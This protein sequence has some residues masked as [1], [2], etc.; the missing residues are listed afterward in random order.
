MG[1][2]A[3]SSD[4]I[5]TGE[6]DLAPIVLSDGNDL[7]VDL[8]LAATFGTGQLATAKGDRLILL[9]KADFDF[10]EGEHAVTSN[11]VVREANAWHAIP[12]KSRATWHFG[13]ATSSNPTIKGKLLLGT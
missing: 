11:N 1:F 5:P 7:P 3:A 12:I 9:V 10:Y 8:T 13:R 4:V 2:G 6:M